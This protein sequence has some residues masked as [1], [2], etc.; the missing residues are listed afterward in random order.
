M[1]I[2]VNPDDYKGECFMI[3]GK[4][5]IVNPDGKIPVIDGN[6]P[7]DSSVIADWFVDEEFDVCA[8]NV[9]ITAPESSYEG[10][11]GMSLREYFSS[12]NESQIFRATRAKALVNWRENTKFC[13]GCGGKLVQ[14]K[15]QN[16]QE[17]PVCG[18]LYFPRIEPCIITLVNK[19]EKILLAK[20]VNRA[21]DT[22]ACIAGFIEAGETAEHAV[23]RE[24][25]EETGI[26][27][28]NVRYKGSQSWPF[29]DQLML[30]FTAEYESGEISVQE[31]EI[32]DA[33][34]FD[35]DN[36]PITPLPGSVAYRLI[37]GK[38]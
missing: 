36:L 7:V 21:T 38:I 25:L 23:K 6:P 34:W 13:C 17:C 24:V 2:R 32:A 31:D 11:K 26:H 16:A 1:A 35:R 28:K 9:S 14:H 18:K 22:Y 10:L 30:A 29:P 20:H 4:D 27:V 3:I 15:S 8:V 5:I 12:H 33:A 19:D 37:H